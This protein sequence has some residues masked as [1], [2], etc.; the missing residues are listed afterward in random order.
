MSD[1]V[2]GRT[3]RW[4]GGG[5]QERNRSISQQALYGGNECIGEDNDTQA[6]NSISCPGIGQIYVEEYNYTF[7][8]KNLSIVNC[9]WNQWSTWDTCSVSC[10]G[11]TQVR[12][13]SITQQAMFSG[14]D[15]LGED[16][17]QQSCNSYGCPGKYILDW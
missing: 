3:G 12:N 9:T 2:G 14:S 8:I 4:C 6:C 5:T 7:M 13:R 15:C 11:G 17:E 1:E 16:S 10:G